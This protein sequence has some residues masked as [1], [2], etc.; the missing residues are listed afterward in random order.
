MK[1]LL[2]AAMLAYPFLVYG[3]LHVLAPRTLA[4]ALGGVLLVRALAYGG[5]ERRSPIL[6]PI[7]L[8]GA[9]LALAAVFNNGRFFLFVPVLINAALFVSFAWTLFTE[10]PIVEIVARRHLGH[11]SPEQIRYCRRVTEVWCVFF[12]ANGGFILWLALRAPLETW[13]AYTGFV[14]YL[15][16]GALFLAEL[17]YRNWRFRRYEGAVTDVL[18]RRLFPPK[19]V[20]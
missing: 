15:L 13:T 5:S 14:S 6:V 10:A 16:L 8:V 7:V 17:T 9:V 11:L 18:F 1:A 3:G 20:G 19:R 4:V 2:A 12:L